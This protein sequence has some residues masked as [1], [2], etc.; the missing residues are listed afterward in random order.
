MHLRRPVCLCFPTS[1]PNAPD[2]SQVSALAVV[3]HS[4][5]TR[6]GVP[7]DTT[8]GWVKS[9]Q[10]QDKTLDPSQ[11]VH[12]DSEFTTPAVKALADQ[13]WHEQLRAAGYVPWHGV[14]GDVWVHASFSCNALASGSSE[15]DFGIDVMGSSPGDV[16]NS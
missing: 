12:S 10:Y 16:P 15:C 14:V 4:E 3:E 2:A 9:W 5:V 11:A 6:I 1:L 13:T 8:G 7:P